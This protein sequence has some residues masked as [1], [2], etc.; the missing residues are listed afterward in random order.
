MHTHTQ[1]KSIE[2][3]TMKS[4]DGLRMSFTISRSNPLRMYWLRWTETLFV[5]SSS[6]ALRKAQSNILTCATK[7]QWWE[8]PFFVV[9]L[10]LR[11]SLSPIVAN[12][13]LHLSRCAQEQSR[14]M[15]KHIKVASWSKRRRRRRKVLRIFG[16]LQTMCEHD[17]KAKNDKR[18]CILSNRMWIKKIVF[19]FFRLSSSL[20]SSSTLYAKCPFSRSNCRAFFICTFSNRFYDVDC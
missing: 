9:A 11:R 16:F 18:C 8:K 10:S 2:K 5:D 12:H 15:C 3:K 14:T 19:F 13:R 7:W 20:S 1:R 4:L 6:S 17:G